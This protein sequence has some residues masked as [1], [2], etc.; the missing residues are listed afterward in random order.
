M[1]NGD[2][3]RIV[4]ELG[5]L[6]EFFTVTI[7]PP[8]AGT[9]TLAELCRDRWA[10][11]GYLAWYAGRL[12]TAEARVAGSILFQG[13][14]AR[15]WSP[16]VA[17]ALAYGGVP[18]FDPHDTRWHPAKGSGRLATSSLPFRSGGHPE[19]M[20]VVVDQILTPLATAIH[21]RARV[22]EALLW[23]NATSALVGS[24]GVLASIRPETT[25]SGLE[26]A[27]KSLS[28]GPLNGSGKFGDGGFVRSS[29]CLFYRVD[30]GG[31]CGD[32]VLRRA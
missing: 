24:L 19:A 12:R 28:Y 25:E 2:Q 16:V 4:A 6:G 3:E 20:T 23:G 5:R 18:S 15:L 30:D 7:G 26:F 14:A 17:G 1:R 29:C 21:N 31:L 11:D 27:R 32:C 10:L 9:R 22:A 8:D 13:L